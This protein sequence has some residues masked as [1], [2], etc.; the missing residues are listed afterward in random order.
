MSEIL[1]PNKYTG[2]RAAIRLVVLHTME[3]DEL[4]SAAEAVGRA[5]ANPARQAS[6]HVGVDTD[7]E[8]RYVD[9]QDT[10]WATPGANS[11]GLQLEMAGRAGQTVG[12]WADVTSHAILER[13]A[14]RT[15]TWCRTY[16]IPVRRLTDAELAAG[17][18]GIIDHHAAT[19]VYGGTHWDVG[20][21]FP[22]AW[23]LAR[24]QYLVGGAVHPPQTKPS[25]PPATRIRLVV[26]GVFGPRS[27]ARLQQWAGVRID[28][29]PLTKADWVAVQRKFGGL[30][31]DG[32]PGRKTWTR[33]Q[34]VTGAHVD[35]WPGPD[36][37]RHL[38]AY[39][40]S[41]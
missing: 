18:R 2:R 27:R 11:D 38:Q 8:C 30:K 41:H 5:F 15:A 31:L 28:S 34:R 13:A 40:N 35:S 4:G 7:S 3:V 25:V 17:A 16:G 39:L 10:A 14:Q 12:N 19:R 6:A 29:N 37:Y 24:V 33:I 20:E 22:W 9:D 23:F 26:D 1:S 36:T 21:H 32:D